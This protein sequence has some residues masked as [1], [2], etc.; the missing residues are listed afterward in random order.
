[1]KRI[2]YQ[3]TLFSAIIAIFLAFIYFDM[4]ELK[5]KYSI[6]KE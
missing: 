3:F 2:K 6:I 4:A 5:F 1:M